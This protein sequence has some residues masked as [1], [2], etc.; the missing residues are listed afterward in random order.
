MNEI[1]LKMTNINKRFSGVHALKGVDFILHRGEIHAL[2]GEN[3]AGKSTLM[4]I[5]TGIYKADSGEIFVFNEKCSFDSVKEAQE[6]G[7]AIIHQEL[8]LIPD[9]TVAQ[10][11]F[12]GREKMISK[13]FIDDKKMEKEAEK[14]LEYVG[15]YIKPDEK[16]RNLT[17][18]KQ[19]MVE[20]A[21]AI[22]FDSKILALDEPTAALTEPETEELFRIMNELKQKGIGMIYISHRMDEIER[23]SDRVTVMRDGEYIGTVNT[24]ETTKEIIVKMMVGRAV[25]GTKKEKSACTHDSPV[26]LEV[27]NLNSAEKIK[28]VSFVLRKGEILG[29]SGLMGAGRT[30][31]ARAICG[32]DKL[33]SGEIY[34]NGKKTIIKSPE[35]AVENGVCYLSEDRKRYGLLLN[36]SVTDNSILASLNNYVKFG[37]INDKK[38]REKAK[39]KNEMLKTKT[40]S[41]AQKLKNLSGGNQQKV[42]I[43][44]WLLRDSDIFIFDEPTRGIDIGAKSEMYTLMQDLSRNGKS[45]IMISS[46]L[47]E[48]TRLSDRVIVMCEGRIT[49]ELPIEEATQENI[50]K[51]AMKREGDANG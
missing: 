43:A 26:V 39:N 18:G 44:R 38:A 5:L 41:M 22:S 8:N 51:Y 20:I 25:S 3:G 29:F 23:I 42:I 19:Q 10:N 9:L 7:I 33:D 2:M 4:K 30:E 46:E 27:K 37:F 34:I 15:A 12:L 21:K 36:K 28:N 50:M 16:V 40:P 35:D 14:L 11:I 31:V 32:V 49:K 45:I 47:S 17:V 48:I 24:G 13:I 6:K 1:I